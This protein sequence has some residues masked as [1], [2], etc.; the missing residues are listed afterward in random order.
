MTGSKTQLMG[1]THP[2]ISVPVSDRLS[3]ASLLY[4]SQKT[5]LP[6]FAATVGLARIV[7]ETVCR[8]SSQAMW[9]GERERWM[10]RGPDTERVTAG[11]AASLT[12]HGLREQCDAS[13]GLTR[14]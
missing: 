12:F 4:S 11:P 7:L 5:D 13:G 9:S 2:S 3:T 10:E 1:T 6:L 14:H 8:A